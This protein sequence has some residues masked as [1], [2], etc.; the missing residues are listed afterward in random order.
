MKKIIIKDK[1]KYCMRMHEIASLLLLGLL[2]LWI[3]ILSPI[4]ANAIKQMD[5]E[6]LQTMIFTTLSL[7]TI[8]FIFFTDFGGKIKY[9]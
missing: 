7:L 8:W 9:E 2:F 6:P 1:D 5:I 4:L 3:H